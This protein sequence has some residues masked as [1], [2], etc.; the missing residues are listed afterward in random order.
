MR[1]G[2]RESLL[3][4]AICLFGAVGCGGDDA[5][6]SETSS[7]NAKS[8]DGGTKSQEPERPSH[9]FPRVVIS[10][11]MGEFVVELDAEKAPITVQNFLDYVD[12]AHYD[13]TIFHQVFG[14]AI[15]LGG[16]FTPDFK[17]KPE[18]PAIYNEADNGLKNLRGTVAMARLPGTIDSAT[19]QFF[20]NT[21]DNPSFDHQSRDGD[22]E[23][24]GY[25][26][27]G[28]VVKG[29]G[30]ID[31]L[32]ATDVADREEGGIEFPSVPTRTVRID[33][34]RRY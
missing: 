14:D 6:P 7:G 3:V 21:A 34:I 30:V 26:V 17:R 23:E 24:Y 18:R 16:G 32:A 8:S 9:I 25:C 27:F 12:E 31:K 33:S 11:N 1:I 28:R 4:C 5:S 13:N 10:T 20:I 15:V 2:I 22:P 29:M 19:C